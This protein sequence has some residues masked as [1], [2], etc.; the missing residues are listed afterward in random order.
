MNI[1]TVT[2]FWFLSLLLA[3]SPA[4]VLAQESGWP[5]ALSLEG[6]SITIY[7]LQIEA[8]DG[9][10]VRYRAALAYREEEDSNPVFGAGWFESRVEIDREK[11]LVHP[12]GLTVVDTRFPDVV[13]DLQPGLAAVVDRQSPG[14][15]LDFPLTELLSALETAK[16]E[17][18]TAQNLN[19]APP[20]IIY[21]DHPALLVTIDGEPVMRAIENSQYQAVINTPYPLIFDGRVYH[22]GAAKGVWYR[23][24]SA[25]G[26]YRYDASPPPDIVTMV[27]TA[28]EE[29]EENADVTSSEKVTAENAPEIIV[30]TTPTELIVTEG[31]AVFVPL[32]DDLLVLSNTSDD[33]FMHI[34]SQQFYVVLAGRWYQSDSLN[35]PWFYRAADNLPAAFADIPKNSQQADSRVYVAGTEE[36]R[37]AVLDAQVP[38][39]AAVDRGVVDLDVNYDG[40]PSF[41]PVEGTDDLAY[42]SNSDSTV[43]QEHH[44]YYLVEDGVWYVSSNPDGPW[45]VSD[46]RPREVAS[47]SPRSPVYNVKYVY[48]YDST[49]EVVYVG[50][51]PGYTSSYIYYDTIVYGTGWYYRPWISPRYYYPRYSTWGFDVSYNPWWGWSFGLSWGWGPFYAGYYSGG[52]WHHNRPW[53]RPGCGYWGPAGYRPRPVHRGHYA[54][55]HYGRDYRDHDHNAYDHRGSGRRGNDI[56]YRD[57]VGND[58]NGNRHPGSGNAYVRNRNLYQDR[59]QRARVAENGVPGNRNGQLQRNPVAG[60]GEPVPRDQNPARK[61][62]GGSREPKEFRNRIGPVRPSE[63]RVKA[64]V[65]D[66]SREADLNRLMAENTGYVR[67]RTQSPLESSNWRSPSA[68][69]TRRA[70]SPVENTARSGNAAT[71]IRSYSY[72]RPAGQPSG[73]LHSGARQSRTVSRIPDR[74][75]ERPA[76]TQRIIRRGNSTTDNRAGSVSVPPTDL[77]SSAYNRTEL[78]GS[79]TRTRETH[80]VT[81]PRYT[82]RSSPPVG[83]SQAPP[84]RTVTSRRSSFTSGATQRVT[85][86]RYSTPQSTSQK[87]TQSFSAPSVDSR[88]Q[89]RD[90]SDKSVNQRSSRTDGGRGNG[91]R[92]RRRG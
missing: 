27:D 11:G 92:S 68:G 19:T 76:E 20:T 4:A 16:Q 14:W 55:N 72:A 24:E 13:A 22:L 69:E 29:A 17:A 58:R 2:A 45:V 84:S 51:T 59:G 5:K 63:L 1:R 15:N 44:E 82:Q 71:P 36:A 65:R 21:R 41:E 56:R 80:S 12:L 54:Y 89:A 35:G 62:A 86:Q 7:P 61:Y 32:V 18:E 30:A 26:P 73:S 88:K 64:E 38:Q 52:F 70:R 37:E 10:L 77:R 67:R 9:D 8:M 79:T 48:I 50:Y 42:A 60:Y 33:V 28:A 83:L 46:Y 78:R 49:P 53:Y 74:V 3:T 6:G 91:G 43:L 66:A 87:S 75:S 47:I 57:Q 31:P 40:D 90:G 34:S 81:L 39:T 23:A 85:L 25:T